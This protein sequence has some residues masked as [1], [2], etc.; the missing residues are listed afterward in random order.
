MAKRTILWTV[1]PHGRIGDGPDA[2]R[3]R[4]S[5]LVSPRLTPETSDETRLGAFE[6][7][8]DWP[9]TLA[10]GVFAVRIGAEEVGL[11]LLSKP[12]GEI[13]RKLF[14]AETPV[15]GFRY[16]DMSRI[17]LSDDADTMA[18]KIRKAKTDPEP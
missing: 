18:Q 12:D 17:N 9:K 1:L 7:F 4:V 15:E 2:G 3:Y 13:W 5:V 6:E 11:R 14:V 10:G 8:L 16:A